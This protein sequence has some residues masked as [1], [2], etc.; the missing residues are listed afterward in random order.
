MT[1]NGVLMM[2]GCNNINYIKAYTEVNCLLEYLPQP[3]IDKLPKKLIELIQNQSDKQ[4]NINI[5]TNKSLLEQNFSKKTKDFIA[6]IKYNYWSTDEERQQLK[7]IFYENESK[8]QAELREKYNPD[9]LFKKKEQTVEEKEI[10]Q[11]NMQL[12]EYKEENIFK[13]ILNRIMK[14]FKKNN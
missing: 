4:Y 14:F 10:K 1:K 9:N 13:K 5:D 8:Y 7:N 3:Y 2:I 6:V 11:E 12:I